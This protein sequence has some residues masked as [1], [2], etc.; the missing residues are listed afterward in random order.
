MNDEQIRVLI[1]L[2]EAGEASIP[3]EVAANI[4]VSD[5]NIDV[6]A[7]FEP[8]DETFGVDVHSL[9]A[10]S[11]VDPMAY[12][13]L[14][15]LVRELNPD[16]VHVHANATGSVA[17][18]L[19]TATDDATIVTTE[20]NTHDDFGH[21]KRILNGVT[22]TLND[23]VI[24]NSH[25]T[26]DSFADWEQQL[27]DTTGTLVRVMH[28]GVDVDAIEQ[29][30]DNADP[31]VLPDGFLVGTAGRLVEQKN[32]AALIRA[33][34]PLVETNDDVHVVL[35]GSGPLRDDLETL[36]T[37]LGIHDHVHF[38]GYLPRRRDV[39]GV[40][41]ALDIF[42]FPSAYEGF[43]VAVAEAMALE[44]PVVVND[45]SV[46]REVVGDAGIFV[47]VEDETSFTEVLTRLSQDDR[48]REDLG[49]RARERI[50][51][52]FTLTETVSAH[53]T[54]YRKSAKR[55]RVEEQ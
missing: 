29:A 3:L 16:V 24:A 10:S 4:N 51:E 1:V 20:H 40:I 48:Q 23:V 28:N 13:R 39:Y 7:F 43:G 30:R 38:L 17:R 53:K 33:A 52:Q 35:V 11:Q 25:A 34:A 21:I 37:R 32:Q 42:V 45:I 14:L 31:P 2:N 5:I 18:V 12:L 6:C 49:R 19:L 54:L 26:R 9:N 55:S 47:D 15:K 44:T 46:L 36:A 27:F 8:D 50:H 41:D 22:N